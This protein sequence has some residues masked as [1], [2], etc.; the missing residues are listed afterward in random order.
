MPSVS[1]LT[2]EDIIRYYDECQVD[3]ALVWQLDEALGMHYG[4]WEA[5]TPH[6]AAAIARMNER[7]AEAGGLRKGMRVLDAGC[8]VGGSSIFLARLGCTVE[9]ITLSEKQVRTCTDNAARLGV[10]ARTRF[11]RQ[12]YLATDFPDATFDAVW[13]VE[14]VCY[15]DDKQDF[16]DE[17][18]RLLK[19]G[20][21]LVVADFHAHPTVAGSPEEALMK[22]WT[23]SWAINAYATVDGFRENLARSG[24]TDIRNRD[25]TAHVEPSIR[26]LFI[27]FFPGLATT[28]I[29]RWLG[30]RNRTQS[31]NT[32]STWYQYHT[33]RRGLWSYHIFSSYKPTP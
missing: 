4:F 10:S 11:S 31:L 22:K 16:T 9:G 17:A 28:S 24:F 23:D 33:H 15:A 1:P 13:A 12:S 8:G 25:V 32:W 20:G 5:D 27:S 2:Q 3:Y 14:S 7:V 26:R 19:P 30:I 21:S 18:Y 6:H 29:G